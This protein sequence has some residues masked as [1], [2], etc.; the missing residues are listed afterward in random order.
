MK[1]ETEVRGFIPLTITLETK[2]ETLQFMQIMQ[3]YM[4]PSHRGGSV[5]RMASTLEVAVRTHYNKD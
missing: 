1:V 3:A 5:Y 2:E 4:V